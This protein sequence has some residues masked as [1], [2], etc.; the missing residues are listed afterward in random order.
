MAS[1]IVIVPVAL[2]V[3]PLDASHESRCAESMT[4]SRAFLPTPRS[5]ASVFETGRS[6][7]NSL[8]IAT[9]S[10]GPWLFDA[11]R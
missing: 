2:S 3:A 4:Y 8:S 5:S 10:F 6:P 1:S 9:R 11:R 7:R